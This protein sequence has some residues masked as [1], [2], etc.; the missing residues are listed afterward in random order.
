MKAKPI[1]KTISFTE[2]SNESKLMEKMEALTTKFDSQFKDIKGEMKE[3]LDGCNSYVDENKNSQPREDA[4]SV[5]PT[6]K[7]K[8]NESDFE[9]IMREFMV[10]QKSSNDFVKNQFFNLKTKVEQGQKN[11]QVSIQDL[12]T[13]FGRFSDQC[14]SRPTGSLP[15]NT[16]T[17]PKPSPTND[18][19]YRPPF[20]QNEHV[21]A[22][23]TR[24][25]LTY[26]PPVNPNSKTTVIHDDSK[27][28]ADEAEKE[29][30]SSSS[31]QTKSDPPPL[32][33]YKLK[34]P[35]PQRLRKEKR[36]NATPNVIDKVTK[37]ELDALLDDSK[38]YSTT[39]KKISESFLDHKFKE[40][41]AIEIEE[42]TKQEEEFKNSFE[43]L[44][45]EGNQRIKNFIK[46]P[47]TD[48]VMKPLSGHLEY[49]FLEKDSLIP[50]DAKPVIQRQ[51]RL[52][53]NMKEVVKKEIIKLLDAG[54][55]CMISIFQDMLETSMEVFMDDFLVFGD[56]FDSYLM[57][58]EQMLVRCKQAHLVINWEKCRFMVTEGIVLGHKNGPAENVAVDHL[59][60][61]ENLHIEELRDDDIDDNF[62]DE[63]LMNVSSTEEDKISCLS[64]RD[65]MP[66]NSIQVSEIF[67]IWGIDFM[68]PFSKSHK[69]E[70]IPV[71]I[72]YMSK[73]VESEALPTNDA[74][75][76]INF[77]KKLFSRFGI[78][79]ALISDRA[80]TKSYHDRKLRIRK[81][82]KARDKI[83]LYN[84]KYKFKAPKL[85]SKWYGPFVVKHGL[86]SSYVELYDKHKGSF[87][88]NGHRVKL[89]HDEEQ[90][91]EMTTEEI[92]L[93]CE[94]GKM[95]A[96][97]FMTPFPTNYRETMPWVAE[98]S[99]IYS[100][101]ENTCNKAKLYDLDETDEGIVKRNFLYVK[102]DPSKKSTLGGK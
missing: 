35:Y 59:S 15:S 23:F 34:I 71:A 84:S 36:K 3:M 56:S 86:P 45:L 22:V 19:P 18:K 73:W 95:E 66:Q 54:K 100:V 98:K 64:Q 70:Y 62:L 83:L 51:R 89:Y 68:G 63:T 30:K 90:I 4:P 94:Q 42:I 16:Q 79:K 72:D 5:P 48:L 21:N 91:N 78:P 6:L 25:G 82:F 49:A 80:R 93:M 28:E 99:F 1:R 33:A 57:N 24:S 14:S 39:L 46:D 31:K 52:N 76:M 27:D 87:I 47:S 101:V 29:V 58:L 41:M 69:F 81:E 8:F 43:V 75:V 32:K 92:H 40:F 96:I 102:K 13:K 11:H 17:N 77:I 12:E 60:R 97:P 85:R 74:R 38:P 67:D 9:K 10:A 37:E 7:K 61:L 20:A 53:P 88:I 65:E 2:S 55:R 50:N 26:D 44:P